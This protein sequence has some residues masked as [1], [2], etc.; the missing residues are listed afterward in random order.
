[1]NLFRVCVAVLIV[2]L[3]LNLAGCC[4]SS[5]KEKV[6]VPTQSTTPTLG[7][8]LEDLEEAYKKGAITKEEF[9]TGKKKLLERG[10]PPAK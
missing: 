1:M 3:G 8:E 9:E 5:S 10:T 2:L 4:S 6:V 7:K